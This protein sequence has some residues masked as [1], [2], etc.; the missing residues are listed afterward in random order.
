MRI[1]PIIVLASLS[2]SCNSAKKT[3]SASRSQLNQNNT[4]EIVKAPAQPILGGKKAMP[5]AYIYK[6]NGDF[7]DNV[8]I[9]FDPVSNRIIYYPDPKDV[10]EDVAPIELDDGWLLERQGGISENTAFLK[11]TYSE[12]HNLPIVPL[13]EEIKEAIIPNAKVTKIVRLNMT[14]SAAQNDT[15][16]VNQMIK[17]G[18]FD[19]PH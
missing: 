16:K 4:I 13:L 17:S 14:A 7:N 2:L 15:V 19:Y 18:N 6:T 3:E 11:W 1:V 8:I 9:N 12:Y 5:F 10:S